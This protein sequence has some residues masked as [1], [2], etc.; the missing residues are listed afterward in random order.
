VAGSDDLCINGHSKTYHAKDKR[1]YCR[2]CRR[3]ANTRFRLK[4][5]IS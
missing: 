4:N 1:F 2:T 5:R 3:D